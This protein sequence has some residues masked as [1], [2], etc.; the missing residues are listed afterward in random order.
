MSVL[1]VL[2]GHR[3]G[4]SLWHL[5]NTTASASWQ[6]VGSDRLTAVVGATCNLRS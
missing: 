5:S 2:V 1:F 6:S 3:A 4:C